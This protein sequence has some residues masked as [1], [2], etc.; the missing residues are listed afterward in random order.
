MDALGRVVFTAAMGDNFYDFLFA[1]L[2]TSPLQTRGLL[3][4]ERVCSLKE[5]ILSL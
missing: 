3:Y 5:Q 1:L 2:H 4:K